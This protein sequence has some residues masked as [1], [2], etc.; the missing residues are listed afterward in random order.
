MDV[1]IHNKSLLYREVN[2]YKNELWIR[3]L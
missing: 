3:S 1:F 2:Y